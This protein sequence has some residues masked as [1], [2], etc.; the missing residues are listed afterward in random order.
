MGNNAIVEFLGT[1]DNMKAY[2]EWLANP[3]T[4]RIL[5]IVEDCVKPVGLQTINGE[6][7]LYNHG[8]FVG[9]ASVLDA[10]QNMASL[11]DAASGNAEPDSLYGAEELLRGMGY[12]PGNVKQKV[13]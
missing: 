2:S 4:R 10:I 1:A 7:A 13:N 11:A 12:M 6:N 9:M 8:V 5:S 3:I